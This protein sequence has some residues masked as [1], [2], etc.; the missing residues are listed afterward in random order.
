M[1]NRQ[2]AIDGAKHAYLVADLFCGAGGTSTGATKAVEE[3]GRE[4]DLVAVNHWP[5]A[6]ETHKLNPNPPIH[7]GGRREDSGRV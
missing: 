5:V 4:I 1:D 2:E 6:V 3:S 7:T